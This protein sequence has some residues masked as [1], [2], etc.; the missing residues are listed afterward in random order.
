MA[1]LTIALQQLSHAY[2]EHD[3]SEALAKSIAALR[4]WAERLEKRQETLLEKKQDFEG[5]LS[6]SE[7]LSLELDNSK[8]QS[9]V[10]LNRQEA[11]RK[12][13]GRLS[14]SLRDMADL[15]ASLEEDLAPSERLEHSLL[16]LEERR[17]Q[18]SQIFLH[19]RDVL[20]GMELAGSEKKERKRSDREK[21]PA[22]PKRL[23]A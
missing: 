13:V 21:R 18:S 6:Y 3:L 11:L 5:L 15:T 7:Q 19:Y 10:S 4:T 12:A 14:R 9:S 20:K 23:A 2:S 22:S 1:D 16:S 17:E 8:P